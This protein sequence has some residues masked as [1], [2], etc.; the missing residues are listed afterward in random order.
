MTVH[1][2]VLLEETLHL[3]SPQPGET[4]VD[5]TFGAGGHSRAIAER[6]GAKGTLV[7]IDRDPEARPRYEAF[8][9][10][11]A[12]STRF[13]AA[14]FAAGLRTLEGE[15]LRADGVL[16]DF[17]LSSPQID[18][19]HR[20]FSYSRD[21]PL[22]MRMDPEQPLSAAVVIA[23]WE[24]RDLAQAFKRFGEERNA[25]QI[26]AAIVR[27]REEQPITTTGELVAVIEA[28]IPVHARLT[29]G[30]PAKRVFQALRIVVN[31]ELDQVDAALPPAW[32]MLDVGGRL[33]AISFH[34][35]EDR[36]V[37]KFFAPLA[38]D[39]ICPPELPVCRC[40]GE[41]EAAL[42]QS[43]VVMAGDT[44]SED[45]PRS[46]SAKLRAARKLRETR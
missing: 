20:G 2:P 39:C 14:D 33:A 28:T 36:R 16:F 17:G 25:G 5:A 8:A 43:G 30:H 41:P 24:R 6:I 13:V 29:G 46:R 32:R 22:D 42:L 7:A 31:G 21:A 37:K 27:A 4:F 10:E 18:D 11:V 44:E 35:L 12:C 15:G 34:S 19:E 26:A 45:N 40:G 38:K 1:L 23:D 3:L 9:A